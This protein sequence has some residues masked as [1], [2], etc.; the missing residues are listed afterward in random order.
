MYLLLKL[1]H[2]LAVVLFLGNI[3]TGLFWHAHAASTRDPK[4]LAHTMAGIIRS[5]RYFTIPG[6]V[7][8]VAAGIGLAILGHFPI[9]RT[10]WILWTLILFAMSGFM[11]AWRVVPLQKQ[12][13]LFAMSGAE[14]GIFDYQHYHR[15]AI[16][17]ELWGAA[18]LLTPLLGLVLMVLKPGP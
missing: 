18:A 11:F 17:W 14:S 10:G 7:I 2:L 5:D 12:L 13:Q 15:L 1:V 6:V 4:L 3:I 8:I 9:F 16:R